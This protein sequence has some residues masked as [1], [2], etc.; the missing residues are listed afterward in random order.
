MG[1]FQR[2]KKRLQKIETACRKGD[3]VPVTFDSAKQ[4]Y[5]R[6]DP[7]DAG[8]ICFDVRCVHCGHILKYNSWSAQFDH[9]AGLNKAGRKCK[10]K[11]RTNACFV[12]ASKPYQNG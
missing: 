7:T 5:V 4:K 1:Y 3:W 8:V 2:R 11:R 6:C 12:P 9:E 10:K